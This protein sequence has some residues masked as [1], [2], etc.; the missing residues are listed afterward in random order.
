MLLIHRCESIAMNKQKSHPRATNP[1]SSGNRRGKNYAAFD[2]VLDIVRDS[3]LSLHQSFANEERWRWDIPVIT[4]SWENGQGVQRNVNGFVLGE[5]RPTGIAIESNA[6][7]DI[8]KGKSLIRYWQHLPTGKIDSIFSIAE[9]ESKD[10]SNYPQKNV[11]KESIAKDQGDY[12][13]QNVSE[14]FSESKYQG[15]YRPKTVSELVE[16]AYK[17]VI[18]LDKNEILLKKQKIN[19]T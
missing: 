16:K 3:F 7:V 9:S 18:S 11:M 6:W 19:L 2:R 14:Q 8:R 5:D 1:I 17:E 15:D 13:R 10:Q 12:L 4:F